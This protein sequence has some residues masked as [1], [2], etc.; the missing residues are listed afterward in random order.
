MVTIVVWNLVR[1]F[2]I[3]LTKL[4]ILWMSKNYLVM[5]TNSFLRF[6]NTSKMRFAILFTLVLF[7]GILQMFD[8]G[9]ARKQLEKHNKYRS[10]HGA[11]NLRYSKSLTRSAK[12]WAR[13]LAKRGNMQHD[14]STNEGENI[15]MKCQSNNY[16]SGDGTSKRW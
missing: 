1:Y 7:L 14:H 8:A 4:L 10:H 13:K 3:F 5:L 6:R 12:R 9:F 16:P 15:Y 2:R 11:N